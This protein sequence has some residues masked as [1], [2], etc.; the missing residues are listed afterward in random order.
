MIRPHRT[1]RA[2]ALCGL[3]A[4]TVA[5]PAAPAAAADAIL[6]DLPV[7]LETDVLPTIGSCTP[8][9]APQPAPTDDA[10]VKKPAKKKKKS[11]KN[12]GCKDLN[13][14]PDADNLERI[15]RSTLCLLNRERTRRG[16]TKLKVHSTLGRVA[17]G[18]A[19]QMVRE[20]FFDHISPAGTTMLARIRSTSYLSGDLARWS[21]G[22][23]LAWGTGALS[24]PSRT[25]KAWMASPGHRRNILKSSYREIGIGLALGVPDDADRGATYVTEFGQRV[26][27]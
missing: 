4:A 14:R 22:E 16:R 17:D 7:C 23:N 3:V 21:V 11:A 27:R 1:I 25:V 2:T 18:Y 13:L 8:A 5:L 15:R 19:D 26:R 9:P 6:P 10:P 12:A 24:T 20:Q